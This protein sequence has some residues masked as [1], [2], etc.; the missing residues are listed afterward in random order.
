MQ[1]AWLWQNRGLDYSLFP[2]IGF[3]PIPKNYNL[4]LLTMVR[5]CT[6][7]P[8]FLGS[9]CNLG[10]LFSLCLV[11][12]S[13]QGISEEALLRIGDYPLIAGVSSLGGLWGWSTGCPS[14]S[15]RNV[16]LACTWQIGSL[17]GHWLLTSK[18]NLGSA[19]GQLS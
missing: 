1:Q 9:F 17:L 14:V 7:L 12:P 19:H 13:S 18:S 6:A 4:S 16:A 2:R 8:W 15:R 10:C 11:A 3:M 5:F